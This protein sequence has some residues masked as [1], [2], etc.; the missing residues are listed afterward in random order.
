MKYIGCV[1]NG[2]D[3]IF[4]GRKVNASAN[5]EIAKSAGSILKVGLSLLNYKALVESYRSSED[6]F[7][8]FSV[9]EKQEPL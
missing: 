8:S 2:F 4:G 1:S 9:A 6:S 7:V 5:A 3:D